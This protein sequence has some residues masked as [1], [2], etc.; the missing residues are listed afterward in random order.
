[1]MDLLFEELMEESS[2]RE[3]WEQSQDQFMRDMEE[4][5]LWDE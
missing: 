5:G 2:Q 3:S 1:M 4:W